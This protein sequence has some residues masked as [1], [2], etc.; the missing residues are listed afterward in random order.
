MLLVGTSG[1]Q[2][3]QA[4]E[5]TGGTGRTTVAARHAV[6]YS[7]RPGALATTTRSPCRTATARRHAARVRR[8]SARRGRTAPW[9]RRRR[10]RVL[11][12]RHERL[13]RARRHCVR[14]APS[15][16][17]PGC[18]AYADADDDAREWRTAHAG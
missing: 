5:G 8:T 15:S 10:L 1:W 14:G 7:P 9:R 17:G 6:G 4:A 18:L 11:Q 3:R 12:Q 2:Y 16:L 13:R